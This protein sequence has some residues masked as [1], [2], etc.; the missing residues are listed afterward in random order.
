MKKI[1][2]LFFCCLAGVIFAK[3]LS[4]NEG[5]DKIKNLPEVQAF[6][7]ELSAN[8]STLMIRDEE[9]SDSKNLYEFYVG[10]NKPDH[11]VRWN[12]F[13][14]DKKSGAVFVFD[15]MKAKYVPYAEW[16]KQQ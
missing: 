3:G 6:A 2:I 16:K 14:V 7:E 4:K 5:E 12:G 10:E 11:T 9:T 1:F 13:G 8:K 15:I